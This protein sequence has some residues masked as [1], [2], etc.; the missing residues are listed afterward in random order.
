MPY[1]S[2]DSL[3]RGVIRRIRTGAGGGDPAVLSA[4][5]V[6]DS[7]K[8]FP[9]PRRVLEVPYWTS[10]IRRVAAQADDSWAIAI[11]LVY[12]STSCKA[13]SSWI[14]SLGHRPPGGSPESRSGH[15]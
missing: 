10:I 14:A 6:L 1:H 13:T 2:G 11:S 12:P 3:R 15:P 4:A 8:R 9:V 7:N 5:A